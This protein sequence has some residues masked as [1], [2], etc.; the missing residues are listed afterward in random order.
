MSRFLLALVLLLLP[1]GTVSSQRAGCRLQTHF[2]QM[3]KNGDG[4]LSKNEFTF[5]A[6][7]FVAMDADSSDTVQLA[8][9]RFAIKKNAS[10]TE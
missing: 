10:P 4:Q 1:V 9:A 8:E 7:S 3:D 2:Q 6:K 5:S